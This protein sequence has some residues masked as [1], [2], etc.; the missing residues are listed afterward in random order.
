MKLAIALTIPSYNFENST[1]VVTQ[2]TA[3]RCVSSVDTIHHP[4]Y[5]GCSWRTEYKSA[6]LYN[7]SHTFKALAFE[8][9][10]HL[11]WELCFSRIEEE[12]IGGGFL[13]LS[14]NNVCFCV[15]MLKYVELDMSAG[16]WSRRRKNYST[17][18]PSKINETI[19][20]DGEGRQIIVTW[21]K[22]S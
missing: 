22:G 8:N 11:H 17:M 1:D 14:C 16:A 4:P 6:W 9:K 20:W 2:L 12:W 15:Y 10:L 21:T 5:A 13:F 3:I 7:L 18:C 19:R